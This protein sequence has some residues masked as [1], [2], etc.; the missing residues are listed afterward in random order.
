MEDIIEKKQHLNWLAIIFAIGWASEYGRLDIVKYLVEQ[1]AD[2]HADDDYALRYAVTYDH[3]EI[4]DY[5][6]SLN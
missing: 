5:L 6:K 2:I 4:V 3:L 1:G